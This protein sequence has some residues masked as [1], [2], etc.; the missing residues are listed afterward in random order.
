MRG[1]RSN[2]GTGSELAGTS[3]AV[4]VLGS[5]T[6]HQRTRPEGKNAIQTAA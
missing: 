2:H 5:G 6:V 3:S 1:S 4:L